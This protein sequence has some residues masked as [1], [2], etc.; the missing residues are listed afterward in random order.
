MIRGSGIIIG[1]VVLVVRN[2]LPHLPVSQAGV[3]DLASSQSKKPSKHLHMANIGYFM[4]PADNGDRVKPFYSALLG[5]MIEPIWTPVD[6]A[7]TAGV[8]R[9]I[10][11]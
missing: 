8:F 2:R 6:A 5:W 10:L 1:M 9:S 11:N 4:I 7:L 3:S